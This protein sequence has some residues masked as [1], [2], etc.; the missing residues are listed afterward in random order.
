MKITYYD[1]KSRKADLVKRVSSVIAAANPVPESVD[2]KNAKTSADAKWDAGIDEDIISIG[3][4]ANKAFKSA[5]DKYLRQVT[6]PAPIKEPSKELSLFFALTAAAKP[7]NRL[8]PAQLK[9]IKADIRRNTLIGEEGRSFDA[10][11]SNVVVNQLINLF[12]SENRSFTDAVHEGT[13]NDLIDDAYQY[14]LLD[15][16]DKPAFLQARKMKGASERVGRL[17]TDYVENPSEDTLNKLFSEL[18]TQI[19][20]NNL[21]VIGRFGPLPKETFD[22]ILA[23]AHK[24][25][26]DHLTGTLDSLD[27]YML[28][29]G[30]TANEALRRSLLMVPEDIRVGDFK[31]AR[32]RREWLK[33]YGDRL[34]P[35]Q[36]PNYSPWLA[37]IDEELAVST[38]NETSLEFI[39]NVG[40]KKMWRTQGD[41]RV[42]DTHRSLDGVKKTVGEYFV[43]GG[44]KAKFP[45]DP[46]LSP[47]QKA[48]CRCRLVLVSH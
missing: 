1:V 44:E 46:S 40:G 39:R 11:I 19:E 42:R 10:R 34:T 12:L 26:D 9:S 8:T 7:I 32:R 20:K 31:A 33:Q 21:D 14:D 27:S 13:L 18:D 47:A 2:P 28:D 29:A 22:S 38:R 25:Y 45:R 5:L 43:V 4:V 24:V 6:V 35:E 37:T 17:Y 48:R 3:E 36:I 41:S 15:E 23:N 16:A 30:A